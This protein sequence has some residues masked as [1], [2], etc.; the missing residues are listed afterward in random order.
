MT[1][2]STIKSAKQNNISEE[3][4]KLIEKQIIIAQDLCLLP[5]RGTLYSYFKKP[6][7][8]LQEDYEDEQDFEVDLKDGSVSNV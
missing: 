5:K 6:L 3:Q 2:Y 7:K 8:T 1:K 4:Q